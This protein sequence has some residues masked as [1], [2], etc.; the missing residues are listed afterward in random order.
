[1]A[2]V[3]IF[4]SIGHLADTG[5][6]FWLRDWQ[7][8]FIFFFVIPA[9]VVILAYILLTVDTPVSLLQEYTAEEM[10]SRLHWMAK[11]NGIESPQI[12]L[13]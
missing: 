12:T 11:L 2:A 3:H 10:Q 1:L 5:I 4:L 9:G 7:K 13:E 8:A 6:F